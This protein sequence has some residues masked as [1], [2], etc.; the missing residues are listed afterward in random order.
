[1]RTPRYEKATRSAPSFRD[2]GRE[3]DGRNRAVVIASPGRF[4]SVS[5]VEIKVTGETKRVW[6]LKAR[7]RP[8]AELQ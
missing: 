8:V 7:P 4:R 2:G 3:I 5:P 6:R 1:L